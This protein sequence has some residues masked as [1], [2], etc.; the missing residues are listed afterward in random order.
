MENKVICSDRCS[1]IR[2]KFFSLGKKYFPTHGC[3]NC[4]SDLH[5]G[6]SDECKKEFK[7]SSEFYRDMWSLVRLIYNN[8]Y[9]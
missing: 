3:D 4:L 6:C 8:Q 7:E 2:K 5:R 1:E 9:D